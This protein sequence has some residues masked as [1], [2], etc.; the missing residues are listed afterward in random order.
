MM[1]YKTKLKRSTASLKRS[2]EPPEERSVSSW[3]PRFWDPDEEY[4]QLPFH[5]AFTRIMIL[6]EALLP[7]PA[8]TIY[9][10]L[11]H[12]LQHRSGAFSILRLLGVSPCPQ[13]DRGQWSNRCQLSDSCV[14]QNIS[15]NVSRRVSP[16]DRLV[17]C[18]CW[19]LC[20]PPDRYFRIRMADLVVKM[21]L[22]TN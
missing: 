8:V 19:E 14:S 18:G 6:T 1:S 5:H 3:I 17:S 15:H 9:N 4:P 2:Q 20:K 11:S 21:Y 22:R 13:R 7:C 16:I 10:R 12:R